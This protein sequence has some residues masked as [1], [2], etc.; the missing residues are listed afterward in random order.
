MVQ[1]LPAVFWEDDKAVLPCLLVEAGVP[2]F[3]SV[4]QEGEEKEKKFPYVMQYSCFFS[5]LDNIK[6]AFGQW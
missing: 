4:T 5:T 2:V 6:Y 3:L 1:F